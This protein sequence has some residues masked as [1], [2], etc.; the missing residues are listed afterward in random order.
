MVKKLTLQEKLAEH[1]FRYCVDYDYDEDFSNHQECEEERICRCSTI[2]NLRIED[3]SISSVEEELLKIYNWEYKNINKQPIFVYA[4]ERYLRIIVKKYGADEIFQAHVYNGYYGEEV[5]NVNIE[6]TT[7]IAGLA[8]LPTLNSDK[9]I[10]FVLIEE[11]GYLLP[12]LQGSVYTIETVLL[13]DIV[14]PNDS[15][16]RK[17]DKDIIESYKNYDGIVAILDGNNHVIDGYHRIIAAQQDEK[18]KVKVIV[19]RKEN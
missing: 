15:Y 5:K 1:D 12:K 7:I 14:I 17:L 8:H 10:E 13:K 6:N 16:V 19:A 9:L 4:L 2:E 18:K 11:Y 3:L